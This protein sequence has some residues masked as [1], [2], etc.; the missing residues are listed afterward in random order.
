MFISTVILASAAWGM[1]PGA[2]LTNDRHADGSP[3]V[4]VQVTAHKALMKCRKEGIKVPATLAEYNDRPR[5]GLSPAEIATLQAQSI[6]PGG[7]Q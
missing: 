3:N 4:R 6:R 5:G 7:E 1:C 2:I